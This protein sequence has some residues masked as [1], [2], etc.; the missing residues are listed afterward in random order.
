M[1]YHAREVSG[2]AKHIQ[3]STEDIVFN[4]FC[5]ATSHFLNV[6]TQSRFAPFEMKT[7]L[8]VSEEEERNDA[9]MTNVRR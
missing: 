8:A 9:K 2:D 7:Q 5:E 1:T 3:K 6:S 4:G